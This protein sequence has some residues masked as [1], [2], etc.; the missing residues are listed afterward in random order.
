M[1]DDQNLWCIKPQ[2]NDISNVIAFEHWATDI[3]LLIDKPTDREAHHAANNAFEGDVFVVLYV[4]G[5]DVF[6]DTQTF[7][8]LQRALSDEE[9]L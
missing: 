2:V 3:R 4:S 9:T 5:N 1:R 7:P 8:G 6:I